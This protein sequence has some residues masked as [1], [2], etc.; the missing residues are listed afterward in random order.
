[1][2][3]DYWHEDNLRLEQWLEEL[4]QKRN[5]ADQE[6]QHA[7]SLHLAMEGPITAAEAAV[8]SLS[9]QIV[10]VERLVERVNAGYPYFERLGFE[11]AIDATGEVCSWDGTFRGSC[12]GHYIWA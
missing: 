5:Q 11:D 4:R 7:R 3:A 2:S 1:M 9:A 12:P 10:H 6:A 8:E